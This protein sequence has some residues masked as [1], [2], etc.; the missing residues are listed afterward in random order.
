MKKL[1]VVCTMGLASYLLPASSSANTQC[2]E[3]FDQAATIVGTSHGDRIIGTSGADVIVARGGG[4]MIRAGGGDDVICGQ[5]GRDTIAG[6]SGADLISGGT[7]PDLITGGTRRPTFGN[8]YCRGLDT[9]DDLIAGNAGHD[10]L[11]GCDGDDEIAG[12]GGRDWIMGGDIDFS[13]LLPHCHEAGGDNLL[14]GGVGDDDEL[15]SSDGDAVIEGERARI[16][17]PS[18]APTPASRST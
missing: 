12:G 17:R 6:Q 9:G 16:P 14:E 3:C 11:V 5:A 13:L 18:S 15:V 4:D 1:A 10:F 2:P 7:G 8:D